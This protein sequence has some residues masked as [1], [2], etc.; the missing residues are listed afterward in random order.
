MKKYI[1]Y[2][3]VLIAGLFL[4]YLIFNTSSEGEKGSSEDHAHSAEE[5]QMWTCSMHP[6]IMQPE[7]GDCPIC[8]MDLIPAEAGADGLTVNEFKMTENAMSLANIQTTIV[9][10]KNTGSGNIQLSGKIE[11]NED[12]TAVMPAH[13]DGRIER[14]YVNTVGDKV[15]MGQ[16][17]AEIYS[18]DLVA[19]QQ[20]L[21]TAYKIRESQPQLYN[22]VR[23]KFRNW[24]ISD[25]QLDRI[26]ETGNVITSFTIYSRVNGVVTEIMVNEGSHIM[27]GKPILKVANLNKVWA[28]FDA[29]E[30][31]ISGVKEGQEIAITLNAYPEKTYNSRI[32][33]VDPVLNKSSRTIEVRA[34]LDNKNDLLKP[35]MFVQGELENT[36]ETNSDGS[37]SIPKSAVLWTGERSIVYVKTTGQEPVFEMREVKLGSSTGDN[38]EILSGINAGEEIVTNGTF[39]VDAAAQLQGKRSMM[40]NNSENKEMQTMSMEMEL[41]ADFQDGFVKALGDY[42]QLK[43]AL[44]ASESEKA[45]N[46]ARTT[47]KSLPKNDLDGMAA[48]HFKKVQEMLDA[49]SR[50][51]NLENQR[52]HFVILSENM[53]AITSNIDSLGQTIYVQHCPMADSNKGADW[54]SLSSEVRNPYYG[55]AMLTCGEVIK[56]LKP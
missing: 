37:L 16:P 42:F 18:P 56:E 7:P 43:D 39:T 41:P 6:Q 34:V 55:D 9:G 30:N 10:G 46:A 3:L 22:A 5:T 54:L 53:I 51:D 24:K 36:N 8:G 21:L 40:N 12:L 2:I 14:L 38:Y 47:L 25:S 15:S 17:V 28:V 19:A 45:Q 50:N 20:E 48:D 27:D 35:G 11:V 31:Q 29:Y 52:A 13:F 4:G 33:Y 49:I 23:K 26:L 1:I 44:V 32:S